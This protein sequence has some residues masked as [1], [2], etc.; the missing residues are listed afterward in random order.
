MWTEGDKRGRGEG[1]AGRNRLTRR[2]GKEG[3][4]RACQRKGAVMIHVRGTLTKGDR[5]E[6]MKEEERR[7]VRKVNTG[8]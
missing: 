4:E 8:A 6:Q 3:K 7:K 1:R 5:G 2:G